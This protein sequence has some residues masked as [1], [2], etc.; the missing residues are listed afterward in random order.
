[1]ARN[2]GTFNFSANYEPLIKAPLDA[3]MKVERFIDL[4]DPNT[5]EDADNLVWLYNGMIVAVGDD[6]NS[7]L[8]GIYFL[9]DADNYTDP[10][11]WVKSG[12]AAGGVN[13]EGGSGVVDASKGLVFKDIDASGNLVF[14]S[15]TGSGAAQISTIGDEIIIGLDAS[16]SGEVNFGE[17]IGDGDVS[18]YAVKQGD[19]LQFR[20]LKGGTNVTLSVSDNTITIDS[21]GGGATY[22]STLDPATEAP[23]DVGGISAGTTVGDLL[24]SSFTEFVD[25]LLFPTVNPTFVNPN[26]SFNDNVNNLQEIGAVI[27]IQFTASFNRGQILLGGV[28]QDFRSGFA[29]TYQYTGTGLI[30]VS[31]NSANNIQTVNSYSV[32][33]G[34]QSWQSRTGYDEGPQPV[35]SKGD[36]FGSPLAAGYTGY[37]STSIEGVYPL[38]GT[39]VSINTLTKRSLVSMISGNN[40]T[41]SL[42]AEVGGKQKIDIPVPWT[43]SRPLV[44]IQTFNTFASTWEYQGGN[45]AQS[46]TFW[47]TS[48]TTQT[49]QGNIINYT[50]Y[51]YNGT[52]RSDVQV[53]LVF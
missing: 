39:T 10:N 3:R 8:N 31:S 16:F 29:N 2:K 7:T 46:L 52:D 44:G 43:T 37:K 50:R 6:P 19:A 40:I 5:W 49:V 34:N 36:D 24:G 1:M 41:F 48:A 4:V 11:N 38:Y 21:S 14:R 33:Q 35:D 51:T 25:D 42:V 22:Q 53:R 32:L 47:T 28:F 27:N 15:I 17:N 13:V 20:E 26:N 9:I 18:I 12:G 45:A 23:E 30:D